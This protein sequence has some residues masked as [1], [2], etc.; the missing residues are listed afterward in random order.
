MFLFFLQE[1]ELKDLISQLELRAKELK[2]E[3]EMLY[4]KVEFV[5]NSPEYNS[6]YCTWTNNVPS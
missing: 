6:S 3:E 5:Q 1:A 2:R 4:S